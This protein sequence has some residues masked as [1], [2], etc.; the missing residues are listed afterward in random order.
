MVTLII[1]LSLIPG[2]SLPK[3]SWDALL[4]VDKWGHFL[5]YGFATASFIFY[6]GYTL[7]KISKQS[8]ISFS[9]LGLGIVLECFQWL[10]HQGRS[11]DILDATA[12]AIGILAGLLL[13]KKLITYY[14]GI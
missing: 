13:G 10:M 2:S 9:L 14:S 11:F 3:L 12:N 7:Q 5:S 6:F 8:I 4:G 1:F